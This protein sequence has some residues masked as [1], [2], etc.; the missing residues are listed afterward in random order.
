M[1]A[2]WNILY[3][4][5]FVGLMA[6]TYIWLS[7]NGL[8]ILDIPVFHLILLSL[9]TFRLIR[10]FTYDHITDYLRNSFSQFGKHTFLG[11]A[12]QLLT[13][14]WCT[15]VWFAFLLY[16]AY[17]AI[18]TI[19][20]PLTLILSIS[21]LASFMQLLSNLIGWSAEEKKQRVGEK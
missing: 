2:V 11:T 4:L 19:V 21:A 13:C 18:P 20:I 16:V 5:F 1:N 3:S 17:A 10:L 7:A 15:G 12:G 6:Y 8:L 9:A 14:P